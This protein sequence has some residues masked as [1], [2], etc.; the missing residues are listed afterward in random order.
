M[1]V[2]PEPQQDHVKDR[3]AADDVQPRAPH[4]GCVL[5]GT[6]G[7]AARVR[8]RDRRREDVDVRGW[9]DETR[10]VAH[11]DVNALE[12]VAGLPRELG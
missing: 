2:R 8:D 9:H 1:T 4:L 7:R 10:L 12:Q 5:L 6:P 3:E 11:L